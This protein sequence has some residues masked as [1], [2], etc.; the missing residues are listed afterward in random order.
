[1]SDRAQEKIPKA[2][3]LNAVLREP[4]LHF[5]GIAVLI[6]AVYGISQSNNENILQVEQREI[7]AKISLQEMSLGE[8]L[9]EEQRELVTAL[10]I[11]EQ[12]L[13]LEALA[14][15][16]DKDERIYN[17]LAQK[18][19]HVLSGN[20]IQPT[21][22][23]L[24]EYYQSNKSRYA[25]QITLTIDELVFNTG[26]SLSDSILLLLNQGAEPETLLALEEGNS[27]PL[28]N[29]NSTDLAN[30]FD[31]AFAETVLAADTN[32]WNGPFI[33]NRG[34]HWLRVKDRTESRT[35][36][37]AEIADRVRLEW[38]ADEEE[39]RLQQEVDKLWDKYSIVI[40]NNNEK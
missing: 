40:N 23:E 9:S 2:D 25:T 1:M 28:T 17:I 21:A 7:D 22:A 20:I 14:M 6:F 16:L 30:I 24:G 35:P 26:E 11:E 10:Y 13:V 38:I 31:A 32:Q 29:V 12:I 4:T 33:S 39:S 15:N 19:R 37:L 34:Q 5:F 3:S 18:M 27:S 8:E 36:P